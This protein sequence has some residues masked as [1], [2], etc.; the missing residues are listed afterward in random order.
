MCIGTP[1]FGS[2]RDKRRWQGLA[3][4]CTATPAFWLYLHFKLKVRVLFAELASGNGAGAVIS[5]FL[6]DSVT[7]RGC[8]GGPERNRSFCGVTKV[9][10]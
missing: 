10:A 5:Y 6:L 9:T 4:R 1:R 7:H 2:H 3:K 8:C